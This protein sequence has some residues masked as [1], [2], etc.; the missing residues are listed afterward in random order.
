M[1]SGGATL[2]RGSYLAE[3]RAGRPRDHLM[4]RG[5][6]YLGSRL[7]KSTIRVLLQGRPKRGNYAQPVIA[8]G[9]A[10]EVLQPVEGILDPPAEFVETLAEAERLL[11]VASVGNN[12]FGST[13]I[14]FLTQFGAVVGL[15]AEHPFR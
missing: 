7:I 12:R 13:L 3:K 14:Q 11:P 2:A 6:M 15:V 10:P 8:R 1:Q 9:D 5:D 4:E